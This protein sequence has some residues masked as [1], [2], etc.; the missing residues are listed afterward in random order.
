MRGSA[1]LRSFGGL[2]GSRRLTQGRGES[3]PRRFDHFARPDEA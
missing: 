3:A 2:A 1:L